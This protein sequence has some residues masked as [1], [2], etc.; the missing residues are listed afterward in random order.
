MEDYKTMQH[1]P[2]PE[3]SVCGRD[4]CQPALAGPE[5]EGAY[6]FINAA[7]GLRSLLGSLITGTEDAGPACAQRPEVRQG[8]ATWRLRGNAP[9]GEADSVGWTHAKAAEA[10]NRSE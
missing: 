9:G 5:R 2:A 7:R 1:Q 3:T 8:L 10:T 6:T 4:S